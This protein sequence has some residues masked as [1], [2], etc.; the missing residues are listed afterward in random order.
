VR[1]LEGFEVSRVQGST[2][3]VRSKVLQFLFNLGR[4]KRRSHRPRN[5]GFRNQLGRRI[6][7]N[8]GEDGR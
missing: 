6:R 5:W 1:L 8:I 7:R 4:I 2:G 3:L